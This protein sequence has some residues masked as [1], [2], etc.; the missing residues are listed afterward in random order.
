MVLTAVPGVGAVVL[1]PRGQFLLTQ[2]HA[3]PASA[4]SFG[5]PCPDPQRLL[6]ANQPWLGTTY[7]LRFPCA[8]GSQ[9]VFAFGFSNTQ[10]GG[11]PLPLGLGFVG[12]PTCDLLVS[13]DVLTVQSP[14][15]GVASQ[16]VVVPPTITLAGAEL[17]HQAAA[18]SPA[19]AG[20]TQG[21]HVVL[22]SLW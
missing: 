18:L 8:A 6:T 22:G 2:Q 10:A 15:E 17:F 9:G 12:L 3:F 1:N 21:L 16:P 14:I 7:T 4:T 19:F 20:V 11:A 5:G 13:L